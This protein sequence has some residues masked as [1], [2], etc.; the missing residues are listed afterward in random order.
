MA[1]KRITPEEKKKMLLTGKGPANWFSSLLKQM[2]VDEIIH[3]PAEDW[4]SK[5]PPGVT[6]SRVGIRYG[7][8]FETLRDMRGSGWV[9][10]RLK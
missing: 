2:E 3:I 10:T 4:K 7:K 5:Y 8:K 6:A 1:I 9:I